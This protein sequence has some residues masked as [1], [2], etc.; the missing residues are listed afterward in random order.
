MSLCWNFTHL[1][2]CF[3]QHILF[4]LKIAN[5]GMFAL[6]L[7]HVFLTFMHSWFPRVKHGIDFMRIKYV[8]KQQATKETLHSEH[9]WF[10]IH[11]K[12]HA[13]EQERRLQ[14]GKCIPSL[15]RSSWE[16]KTQLVI[17]FL[18]ALLNEAKTV[19][20]LIKFSPLWC[21]IV[22][23]LSF[24]DVRSCNFTYKIF[25][26]FWDRNYPTVH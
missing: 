10:S 15:E 6:F 2:R 24:Y 12:R 21:W 7:R 26:F 18:Q 16:R 11:N 8:T 17:V 20:L 13:W 19:R 14:K 3:S 9:L 22:Q 4:L 1:K 23:I 25:K 5:K